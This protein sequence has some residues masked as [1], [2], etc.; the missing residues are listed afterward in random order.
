MAALTAARVILVPGGTIKRITAPLAAG[1]KV[2]ENGMACV[3][4]SNPGS[5]NKGGLTTTQKGVGKF[6]QSVDNSAGGTT[7]PVGVE[8]TREHVLEYWDS[9]TGAGAITTANLYQEVYIA[10]DHELTTVS[11]GAAP[12]GYVWTIGPQGYPNAVG[13]EPLY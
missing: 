3:D 1:A 13:V 11:S 8:L 5:F 4:P 10:S 2:W 7:V 6:T 9:V 12:Y